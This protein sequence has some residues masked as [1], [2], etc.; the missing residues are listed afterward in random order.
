MSGGAGSRVAIDPLQDAI[1]RGLLVD[2]IG[3]AD[4]IG[5]QLAL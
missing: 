4:L 1:E 2:G 5:E 3:N